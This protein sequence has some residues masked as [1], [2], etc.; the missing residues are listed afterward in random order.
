MPAPTL[1]LPTL[2]KVLADPTR[3]RIL[4]LL[5]I[6]ELSVG[7]LGRALGMAQSRVSNH[8]RV[9][10]EHALL[11]ERH[12]GTS[13]FLR[14]AF[15]SG[16]AYPTRLW[17]TLR[18]GLADLTEHAADRTR[19]AGVIAARQADSRA[20]FDR[21]AGD[22]DKLGARFASGQARQ[23]A[24]ASLLPPRLTVADLGCGTGYV[25]RALTGLAERV[26]CVDRSEGM[27]EE[28]RKRLEPLPSGVEFRAGELDALPIA[29]NELD[30]AVVAMVLHHVDALEGP[31]AE[32]RRVI[33]PGGTAVVLE[34]APHRETWMHTELGDRHLGLDTGDVTAAFLRA[35]FEDISLE[36]VDDHYCPQSQD[37]EGPNGQQ[38]VALPLYIVR[39]HVPA[40][41]ADDRRQQPNRTP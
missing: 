29:D 10:R 11:V 39:G 4:G 22:W 15:G 3:L 13:T 19:L 33:R 41:R 9:L 6:D 1:R 16:D 18:E 5:E 30:G 38:A 12:V 8:L 26:I 40:G 35:G 27:L 25:A 23:R 32:M 31:L 36:P 14:T 2:L 20:F 17:T 28:A 24:V 34:L 7:E 37:P 21:V